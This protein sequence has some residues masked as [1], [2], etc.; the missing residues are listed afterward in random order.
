[1]SKLPTD[2]APTARASAALTTGNRT[3]Q[4]TSDDDERGHRPVGDEA[5]RDEAGETETSEETVALDNALVALVDLSVDTDVLGVDSREECVAVALEE[6]LGPVVEGD[7]SRIDRPITTDRY[8][9]EEADPVLDEL[10]R[11]TVQTD[12]TVE[13]VESFVRSALFDALEFDPGETEVVV[14][15]Y[16]RYAFVIERLLADDGCRHDTPG[17][18]VH[19]A[20]ECL[21]GIPSTDRDP[22]APAATGD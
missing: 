13:A 7:R 11:L 10:L 17:E 21:F 5:D 3:E 18:V 12:P 4:S 14:T 6:A 8:V 15:D 22:P 16:D 1:M 20:V 2:R 19:A 9:L